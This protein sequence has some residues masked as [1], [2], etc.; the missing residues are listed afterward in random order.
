[1]ISGLQASISTHIAMEYFYADLQ[2][3]G[4]GRWGTNVPL[5]VR[6]VG[7]HPARVSNLYF[8]FLFLARA[9][10]KASELLVQYDFDTGFGEE[11]IRNVQQLM[12]TL[13]SHSTS[14]QSLSTTHSDSGEARV[15]G[16]GRGGD[17]SHL[18]AL[19]GMNSQGIQSAALCR[20]GFDESALFQV[21]T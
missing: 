8:T 20:K 1:M 16:G 19:A 7:S 2:G 17:T 18:D 3:T 13:V 5:F 14:A 21:V 9:V 4:E 10:A 11:E 15:G 12:A 6:A